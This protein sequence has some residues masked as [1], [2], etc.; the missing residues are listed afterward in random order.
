MY[1][2]MEWNGMEWNGMY[3]CM[4]TYLYVSDLVSLVP[5]FHHR[6]VRIGDFRWASRRSALRWE[7]HHGPDNFVIA[8]IDS[9]TQKKHV[10]REFSFGKYVR[11]L[12]RCTYYLYILIHTHL[13]T[14]RHTHTLFYVCTY[15]Y[16]LCLGT[17]L[18]MIYVHGHVSPH[19]GCKRVPCED[20]VR[21]TGQQSM[22]PA[23]SSFGVL[24]PGHRPKVC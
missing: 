18:H 10:G 24:E 7:E 15:I 23:T 17:H 11:D 14:Q 2:C 8:R 20:S 22:L 3:V 16:D 6:S 4:Y 13:F 12:D 5:S 21:N 1:V 9:W 19:P